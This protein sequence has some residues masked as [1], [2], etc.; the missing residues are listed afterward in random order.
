MAT[1][2][3]SYQGNLRTQLMHYQ[4]GTIIKTDAPTDNQ[5]KGELFS[6]TDLTATSLAACMIT[7]MGIAANG[8]SFI[9]GEVSADIQKIMASNPRR[10]DKIQIDFVFPQSNYDEKQKEIL[11]KAALNCPVAKSLHPDIDQEITFEFE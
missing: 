6:P 9:L 11:K 1:A 7:L 8:H 3:I 5:G 10:I 2:H 4:S